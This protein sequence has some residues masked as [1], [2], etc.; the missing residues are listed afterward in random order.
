MAWAVRVSCVGGGARRTGTGAALSPS[1]VVT[2]EHVIRDIEAV[3]IRTASGDVLS[4]VVSDRDKDLDVATLVPGETES[5]RIA[6]ESLVVPRLLWRGRWP[7]ANSGTEIWAESVT[8]EPD[9]ARRMNVSIR[10]GN[11]GERRVQF[12]VTGGRKGVMRGHSGGPVLEFTG[13]PDIP[14]W[15]FGVVRARDEEARGQRTRSDG[16]IEL[17]D[18]SGVGWMVPMDRV[19]ARF[20]EVAT[21][22]ETPVERSPEWLTHWQ[23]RSRGVG[24]ATADG[25][26]YAGNHDAYGRLHQHLAAGQPGL[27]VVTGE[28]SRGKSALLARVVVLSCHRYIT[29]L[30]AD[31]QNAGAGYE[32]LTVPVDV[33]VVARDLGPDQIAGKVAEQLGRQAETVHELLAS[34]QRGRSA[35]VIVIDAVDES[36]DP[37]AVVASLIVPLAESGATLA[38]GLH[39][40]LRSAVPRESAVWVNLDGD[41]EDVDALPKYV[42]LRLQHSGRYGSSESQRVA[43]AVAA[44]AKGN[45]LM[46][47]LAGR[48]L[49]RREPIDTRTP[50]WQRQLPQ[51]LHEALRVYVERFPNRPKTLALLQ[52]LAHARGDGLTLEPGTVWL[53]TANALRGGQVGVLTHDD[54]HEVARHAPD[55]LL[56]DSSSGPHRLF[57]EGLAKALQTVIAEDFIAMTAASSPFDGGIVEQEISRADERFTSTLLNLL[58]ARDA[59]ASAYEA[60]DPYLLRHIATHLADHG[61]AA[62]L[63]TRPG[64][65]LMADQATVRS[66]LV[67]GARTFPDS[68][69]PARVAA[70]YALGRPHRTHRARAAALCGALRRQSCTTAAADVGQSSGQLPY[71]LLCGPPLPPLV[72]TIADAHSQS[73]RGLTVTDDGEEPLLITGGDDGA[74]RSWTLAG[75]PGRLQVPDAHLGPI[76]LV[77]TLDIDGERLVITF[78]D[79]GAVRSWTLG[80]DRGRLQIDKAHARSID[81]ATITTGRHEGLL[82]TCG[83]D[84]ELRTWTPTGEQHRPEIRSTHSRSITSVGVFSLSGSR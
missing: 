4:F 48:I 7:A 37:R 55:Y 65:L 38:I 23:P 35:P 44:R 83:N 18:A 51:N 60:L 24:N 75:D 71:E 78:G 43:A 52:P 66:A 29:S 32:P 9:T 63:L 68:L 1:L 50:G 57:H 16:T 26:F 33:A 21:L 58:P 82:I 11:P 39:R 70:V 30:G 13:D 6:A 12:D 8:D 61:W 10:P 31:A 25:Y 28:R 49:A 62:E 46:A 56:T 69:G 47:D 41:Y 72:A 80:G 73:I 74:L 77:G 34:L 5:R 27:L 81:A 17:A 14:P 2:A 15:I 79:D 22:V 84:R 19:A 53:A 20:P 40:Y 42:S 59:P 3:D 36:A 54:L 76:V 45:F 67:R 64:L